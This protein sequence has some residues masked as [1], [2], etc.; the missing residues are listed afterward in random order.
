MTIKKAN[1]KPQGRKLKRMRIALRAIYAS[2]SFSRGYRSGFFFLD[3][4]I[5]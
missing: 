2:L 1:L 3:Q 4:E 5:L